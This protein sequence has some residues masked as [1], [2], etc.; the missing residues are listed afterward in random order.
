MLNWSD[1]KSLID[2]RVDGGDVY[3]RD[4]S[5]LLGYGQERVLK[6]D[7]RSVDFDFPDFEEI[8]EILLSVPFMS[9]SNPGQATAFQLFTAMLDFEVFDFA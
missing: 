5:R 9:L 1:P 7:S 2:S 4:S 6:L 3:L 8:R